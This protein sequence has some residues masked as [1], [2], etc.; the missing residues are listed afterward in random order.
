[1][2]YRSENDASHLEHFA[3]TPD[4]GSSILLVG[5]VCWIVCCVA[6]SA[7]ML[8]AQSDLH[9]RSAYHSFTAVGRSYKRIDLLCHYLCLNDRV[10]FI[11]ELRA[12]VV[13]CRCCS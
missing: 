2:R 11:V 3:P 4:D 12:V 1:M 7:L 9:L 8:I 13:G 5:R 6:L 10:S